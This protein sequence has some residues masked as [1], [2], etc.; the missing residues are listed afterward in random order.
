MSNRSVMVFHAPSELYE[1]TKDI[2]EKEM[3][4]VSAFCRM[5]VKSMVQDY[6]NNAVQSEQPHLESASAS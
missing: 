3:I 1:Q 4:S 2:A 5:A 6:R